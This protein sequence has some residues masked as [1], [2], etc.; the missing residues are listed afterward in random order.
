[1][2]TPKPHDRATIPFGIR[3]HG[4]AAM[5]A[6]LFQ[7]STERTARSHDTLSDAI[8]CGRTDL[9]RMLAGMIRHPA[10]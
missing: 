3:T 9:S 5:Q 4:L 6:C 1:M 8:V 2:N 10:G 7:I